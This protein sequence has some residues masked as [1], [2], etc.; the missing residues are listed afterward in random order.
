M[1]CFVP[2]ALFDRIDKDHNGTISKIELQNWIKSVQTRY[3]TDDVERQWKKMNNDSNNHISWDEYD[4]V[5]YHA[6]CKKMTKLNK[7]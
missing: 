5:I 1:F 6:L 4:Q 3:L 2:S 7:H